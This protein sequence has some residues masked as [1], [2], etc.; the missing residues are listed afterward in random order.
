MP[1]ENQIGISRRIEDV[2]ERRRL[3]QIL[4]EAQL[5][6]DIG[7]I[8]RTVCQGKSKNELIRDANYLIKTWR[9]IEKQIQ[10]MKPPALV[11]SELDLTLR[12]VR[13]SFSEDVHKL[14][15]DSKQEYYRIH[16]FMHEAFMGNMRR[17]VEFYR[18]NDLFGDKDIERQI[19]KVFDGQGVY[20]VK[21]L[22]YY[23][24][25]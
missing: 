2:E 12:V 15:V 1:L 3:R 4:I 20:E 11:Y 22:Y 9:R 17:K 8:V 16:K 5:P 19:A 13:D 24:A 21:G 18:G 7:F 23:R 6:R 14:I 25:D 10:R